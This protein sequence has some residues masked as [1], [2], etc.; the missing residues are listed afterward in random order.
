M[1][2][3]IRKPEHTPG[4]QTPPPAGPE[5]PLDPGLGQREPSQ[6]A[7]TYVNNVDARG[8]N[9]AL[10]I[11]VVLLVLAVV[12]YFVLIPV[13]EETTSSS[14]PAAI[15]EPVDITP[16]TTAEPATPAEPDAP[17][18]DAPTE[19]DGTTQGDSGQSQ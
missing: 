6:V 9:A 11:G 10:I 4:K 1:A 2:D 13:G 12:G 3:T 14:E 7:P 19:Q 17:P 15:G 8:S 16:D 18:A 5:D